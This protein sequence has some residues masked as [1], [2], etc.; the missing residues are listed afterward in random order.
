[1]AT[2]KGLPWAPP[3]KKAIKA[4]PSPSGEPPKGRDVFARG[5][6]NL[7]RWRALPAGVRQKARAGGA[8]LMKARVAFANHPPGT[9]MTKPPP[10]TPPARVLAVPGTRGIARGQRIEGERPPATRGKSAQA[11]AIGKRVRATQPTGGIGKTVSAQARTR[12]RPV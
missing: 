10:R 4:A 3:T 7:A 1:M 8:K 6:D 12:R 9:P 5:S 11:P 2:K